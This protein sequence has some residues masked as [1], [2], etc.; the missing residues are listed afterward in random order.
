[1]V[2]PA[3]GRGQAAGGHS[4]PA[5]RPR[6][7]CGRGVRGLPAWEVGPLRPPWGAMV[8]PQLPAACRRAA[9]NSGEVA[10]VMVPQLNG[11]VACRRPAAAGVLWCLTRHVGSGCHAGLARARRAWLGVQV[12]APMRPGWLAHTLPS[13]YY[14]RRQLHCRTELS[15]PSRAEQPRRWQ[16]TSCR[17]C[18]HSSAGQ[19]QLPRT[20]HYAGPAG[21]GGGRLLH[22]PPLHHL[23]THPSPRHLATSRRP[24]LPPATSAFLPLNSPTD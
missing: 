13:S 5:G 18:R 7:D 6:S 3:G 4:Q 22:T 14:C 1:M 15:L 11:T 23:C 21:R 9:F 19:H 24:S 20:D 2:R 8:P 10:G 17:S 16:R 12:V